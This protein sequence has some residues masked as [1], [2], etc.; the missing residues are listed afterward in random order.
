MNNPETVV[1]LGTQV[2]EEDKSKPNCFWT[3]HET[4]VSLGTQVQEEDKQNT[5]NHG[6]FRFG[7]KFGHQDTG[8]R[9]TKHKLFH[10]QF[11]KQW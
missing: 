7:G 4:V 10:G 5:L 2:Q 1:S 9:Q 8:G 11:M 6:Q 3:I